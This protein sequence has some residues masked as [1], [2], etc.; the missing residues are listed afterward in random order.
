MTCFYVVVCLIY[1]SGYVYVSVYIYLSETAEGE[2][3]E[4]DGIN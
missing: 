3:Q 4:C 1:V 2:A